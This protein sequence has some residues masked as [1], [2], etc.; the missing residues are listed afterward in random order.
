VSEPWAGR[1]T[2]KPVRL[3]LCGQLG[4]RVDGAWWPQTTRLAREL[5]E[6]V[7]ILYRRMGPII[8]MNINWSMSENLPDLNSAQWQTKRQH[9]MRL[10]GQQATATIL[11][12]PAATSGTL[13]AMVMRLAA[14]LPVS[15]EYQATPTFVTAARIVAAAR[16]DSLACSPKITEPATTANEQSGPN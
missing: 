10:I 15:A 8:G 3:T 7:A 13:A 9:V 11:V 2:A 1:R 16:T 4:D 6:L 12:V 5:P 14:G